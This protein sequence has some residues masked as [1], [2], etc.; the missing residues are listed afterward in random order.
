LH[1]NAERKRESATTTQQKEKNETQSRRSSSNNNNNNTRVGVS[2]F[3]FLCFFYLRPFSF[4]KLS[5]ITGA[6]VVRM[7]Q[8]P[9]VG[10]ALLN[11]AAAYFCL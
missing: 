9:Y 6:R 11:A 4:G 1:G 7:S 2:M 5:L 8:S 3:F 10:C